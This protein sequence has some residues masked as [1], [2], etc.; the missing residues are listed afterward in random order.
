MGGLLNRW[1]GDGGLGPLIWG[2]HVACQILNVVMSHVT[3]FSMLMNG[4]PAERVARGW[5]IWALDGGSPNMA[6]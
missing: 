2:P 5:R 6:G 4:R 1:V 3:I